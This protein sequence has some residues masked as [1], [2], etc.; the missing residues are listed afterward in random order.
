M[1][2][3]TVVLILI[4]VVAV[5]ITILCGDAC[6]NTA[7]V[8]MLCAIMIGYFYLSAKLVKWFIFS[9]EILK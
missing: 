1:L 7:G 9:L 4:C 8:I 6:D 5:L 2:I 3:L